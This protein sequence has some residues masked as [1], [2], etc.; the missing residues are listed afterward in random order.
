MAGSSAG[1]SEMTQKEPSES[2]KKLNYK[3]RCKHADKQQTCSPLS[4]MYISNNART[5]HHWLLV[6]QAW[7]HSAVCSSCPWPGWPPLLE[8]H[9]EVRLDAVPVVPSLRL[10]QVPA[11]P[12]VGQFRSRDTAPAE[13]PRCPEC[14]SARRLAL[15]RTA[16]PTPT[17]SRLRSPAARSSHATTAFR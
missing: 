16:R 6:P 2:K 11:A 14:Q 3:L 15:V 17:V 12:A 5:D 13:S 9:T 10:P 8:V 4:E 7:H 1:F